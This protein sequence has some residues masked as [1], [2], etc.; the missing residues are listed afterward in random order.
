MGAPERISWPPKVTLDASLVQK[1]DTVGTKVPDG[2]ACRRAGS[3]VGWQELPLGTPSASPQMATAPGG[4][5]H[6][7]D[8]LHTLVSLRPVALGDSLQVQLLPLPP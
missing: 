5:R 4:W 7:L 1:P 8:A 2:E 3:W 6:K